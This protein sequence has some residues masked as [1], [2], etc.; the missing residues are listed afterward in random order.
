MYCTICNGQIEQHNGYCPYCGAILSEQ[1]I[2]PNVYQNN[3][4]QMPISMQYQ[5]TPN[6]IQYTICQPLQ[7]QQTTQTVSKKKKRIW[8]PIVIIFS[9][10]L[11]G[12][13][14]WFLFLRQ[15]EKNGYSSPE[16]AIEAYYK[17]YYAC[18]YLTL[19]KCMIPYE[20]EEKMRQIYPQ[21][22]DTYEDYLHENFRGN[23]SSPVETRNF[24]IV[25]E[26]EVHPD[27]EAY[28]L[29][30]RNGKI[31]YTESDKENSISTAREQLSYFLGDDFKFEE[32][33]FYIINIETYS[34]TKNQWVAHKQN[35]TYE[36]PN[37]FVYKFNGKWFAI[38]ARNDIF[39][40]PHS[41]KVYEDYI[42][43]REE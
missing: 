6:Q 34:T 26:V 29:G 27:D 18:D 17:S 33:K 32:I 19:S 8:I 30:K 35:T 13:C 43:W 11:I 28:P 22:Y 3:D 31:Y 36:N 14:I 40:I 20:V 12:L 39:A 5:Q 42:K 7:N 2:Q 21:F 15:T 16:K 1:M 38:R 10:L 37:I 41:K 25:K 9:L 24:E 4:Q 23:L